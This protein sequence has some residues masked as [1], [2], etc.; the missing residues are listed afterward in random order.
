M[1]VYGSHLGNCPDFHL[2]RL[3]LLLCEEVGVRF[4]ILLYVI[5]IVFSFHKLASLNPFIFSQFYIHHIC[6]FALLLQRF[7]W[8]ACP[9]SS[10]RSGV[11]PRSFAVA[12]EGGA[13][14]N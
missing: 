4:G 2:G 6:D 12:C 13:V 9:A 3:L 10:L 7:W 1:A 11:K 14:Q 8:A 5:V